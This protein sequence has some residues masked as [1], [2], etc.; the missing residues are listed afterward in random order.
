MFTTN[1]MTGTGQTVTLSAGWSW[2]STYLDI[3]LAQLEEALGSAGIS[4]TSQHNG[5]IGNYS[6]AWAGGLQSISPNQMYMLNLNTGVTI[7]LS[8]TP[9]NP[10][11]CPITLNNGV[12][13]IGYPVSQSMSL[14]EAFAGANPEN[15][16]MVSSYIGSS[17]YYNG[18]WYG[19]IYTLEPGQG[20][21]YTSTS[22]ETKTFYYPS[23][24][25]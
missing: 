1:E 20:Y 17:M 18:G 12:N 14:N 9:V 16:D 4:I 13:W 19:D 23:Q 5:F 7:T 11:D 22:T 3:D 6:G 15:G 2:W 24:S 21:I 25:K 10:E 8:G